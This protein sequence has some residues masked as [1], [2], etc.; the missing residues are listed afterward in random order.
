MILMAPP[1]P[2]PG[3]EAGGTALRSRHV[4][5]PVTRAFRIEY[6]ALRAMTAAL[7]LLPLRMASAFGARLGT[8]GYW[9]AGI[10][11]RVVERHVAAAFPGLPRA[12]VERI[13]RAS[14][15]NLGRT[16][17]E[18]AV[19]PRRGPDAVLAQVEGVD[20]WEHVE[21]A[22][23]GGR[24]MIFVAGH[25]GNWELAGAYVAARVPLD[26]VAMH[27]ANPLVD[28]YVTSTRQRL[29][30]HV[31]HDE[32][33]VRQVPRAVREG[34]AVAMLIDQ[35][36]VGLASTWVPFFGRLA[37]T[38]RGPAVFALRLDAPVI[39]GMA[40]RQPSGKYRMVFEPV[41]IA[42]SG[43]READVDRIAAEYTAVLERWV[44]RLPEQYFWQH[45]RWKH[46]QPGTPP[47]LGEPGPA[48]WEEP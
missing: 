44:R 20:G 45:R 35:G 42:H 29:G 13:A 28:R 40:L 11:R 48:P 31:V 43:D 7:A 19:L 46:Q 23:A 24:G 34:R 47:E 8:L 32:H 37:R 41:E 17:V 15:A 4:P 18:A 5:L 22:R 21:R 10:R 16:T 39:F 36:A 27:L 14:Y 38:P 30:M 6:A 26:A 2:S 33:A 3:H 25:I 9:P 12:E 1:A